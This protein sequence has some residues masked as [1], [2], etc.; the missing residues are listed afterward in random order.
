M[1]KFG[2]GSDS[3]G[4]SKSSKASTTSSSVNVGPLQRLP[5]EQPFGDWS[6]NP[7]INERMRG[8]SSGPSSSSSGISTPKLPVASSVSDP[9]VRST[10]TPRSLLEQFQKVKITTPEQAQIAR[11]QYIAELANAIKGQSGRNR[12]GRSNSNKYREALR[13]AFEKQMAQFVARDYYH[14]QA[15]SRSITH[16]ALNTQTHA[17]RYG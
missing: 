1:T 16:D 10:A 3:S 17:I 8:S 14:Q 5:I 12:G 15:F 2:L 11:E 9:M 7:G 4:S 6:L 13:G